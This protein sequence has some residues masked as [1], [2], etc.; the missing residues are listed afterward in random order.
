MTTDPRPR[1]VLLRQE[2]EASERLGTVPGP[3][4]EDLAT[5][6][7]PLCTARDAEDRAGLEV[8]CRRILERLAEACEVSR[9]ALKLLG[10]RP[11]STHEGKLSYELFGDY[12][13]EHARIR[14]WT[15]TAIQKQWASSRTLLSTLC[16]E[17]MHHLD[18]HGLGFPH[19]FHTTG[20]FERTHRLY[21]AVLGR[22]HYPLAWHAPYRNGARMIDWA[23]TNRRKARAG[24]TGA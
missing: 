15:R 3:P 9:P 8:A 14:L 11:H 13:F 18:V 19:T 22:P 20:F 2:Y 21:Q 16:H 4:P 24:P 7:D 23:E 12:T 10:P 1:R 17:F 6:F 5:L